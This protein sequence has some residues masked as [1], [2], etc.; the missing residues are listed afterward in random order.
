[1]KKAVL[2]TFFIMAAHDIYAQD[3]YELHLTS[4]FQYTNR[5]NYTYVR[6]LKPYQNI[7]AFTDYDRKKNKI[8]TGFFTDSTFTRQTGYNRF[9]DNKKLVYEGNFSNG[10][11]VGWWYFYNESEQ[12]DDSL[13]YVTPTTKDALDTTINSKPDVPAEHLRDTS[14]LFNTVDVEADFIG[15]IKAWKK[16]L[17]K[18]L[19]FP[20]L[21]SDILPKGQRT[22]M[23]EFIV[24]TDGVICDLQVIQSTHPLL[25][26]QAVKAVRTG[27]NWSPAEQNGRKVK[28]YRK[29]PVTFILE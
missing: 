9:Y 28:A 21:A 15:G 24:C 11:P 14:K 3:V 20:N 13:F 25:D 1:M 12:L 19:R 23:I 5:S 22:S 2:L 29:Q 10:N 8:Q 7:W 26:L 6:L 17:T 27:G 16:H 18:V 4:D